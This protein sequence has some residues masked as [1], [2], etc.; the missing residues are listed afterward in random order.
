MDPEPGGLAAAI[1]ELALRASGARAAVWTPASGPPLVRGLPTEAAAGRSGP[2]LPSGWS[3]VLEDRRPSGSRLALWSPRPALVQP[4]PRDLLQQVH[5]LLEALPS[6]GAPAAPVSPDPD[7][8]GPLAQLRQLVETATGPPS[9]DFFRT[10]AA[11][12]GETLGVRLV[13]IGAHDPLYPETLQVEALWADG[14]L[15]EAVQ[16]PYAGTPCAEATPDLKIIEE[17]LEERFPG[18]PLVRRWSLESYAGMAVEGEGGVHLGN[19]VVADDR[20]LRDI[21]HLEPVLRVVAA[22]CRAELERRR[23]EEQLVRSQRLEGLGILAGG[24]AH[25]FNNLLLAIQG[26]LE[27]LR[28]R[29]RGRPDLAPLLE[30]MDLAGRQASDL[31]RKLLTFAG[32][33]PVEVREV[34]LRESAEEA[35]RLVRGRAR[36]SVQIVLEIPA[37]LPS[38][39]A[40]R[41]QISQILVNLLLNAI[42]ALGEQGG[43][44]RIAAEELELAPEAAG[45]WSHGL[46][47]EP[48]AYVRVC[49]EDDGPGIEPQDLERIFDPFYSTRFTGRGL[50]LAS[51]HGILRA[52][53][54]GIRVD[55]RPGHGARFE[56]FLPRHRPGPACR[57]TRR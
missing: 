2:S 23:H 42:E 3:T 11:R 31:A 45:S 1:L 33:T 17:G 46:V 36:G 50:G 25:D 29:L 41:T 40:D 51:V 43:R 26:N 27:I 47:P 57:E 10:L 28:H 30:D 56:I 54:G 13:L 7:P 16:I 14:T 15:Q 19:L 5:S 38:V 37:D 20:P 8:T 39:P 18:S 9:P 34:D 4:L 35:R 21:P 53:G 24:V 48:G 49:V 6:A 22:R 12:L 32:N 52:H 44:I 55:S